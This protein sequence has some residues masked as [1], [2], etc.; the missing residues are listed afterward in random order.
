MS[1]PI[2]VGD[3]VEFVEFVEIE[4]DFQ[5]DN[6]R[7]LEVTLESPSGAVSVIAQSN[8]GPYSSLCGFSS[9]SCSLNG[10]F[11]FGSAR[12]LGENPEGEWILRI[13]DRISGSNP[14]TLRSWRLTIYGHRDTPAAPTIDKVAPGNGAL[15]VAWSA[16]TNVGKSSISAYDLRYILSATTDK[17]D[18]GWTLTEDVWTLSGGGAL[19]HKI[20]GLIVDTQYD[21]QVRAVSNDGDGQWSAVESAAASTDKAPFIESLTLVNGSLNI[22]WS[23][24]TSSELGTVT[25]YDLRY[26]RSDVPNKL[27]ASW[28]ELTFIWT[29]GSLEYTLFWRPDGVSYD[30]QIRAVTGSDQQPWSSAHSAIGHT[31]P[32][33]PS[34]IDI[35]DSYVSA[36]GGHT[37]HVRWGR[38]SNGGAAITGYEIRY[39]RSDATD[40]GDDNWRVEQVNVYP[41]LE[42]FKT[43]LENGV[44]YDV[45]VR[46]VNDAGGGSWSGT[47]VGTPSTKPG[48]LTIDSITAGSKSITV[49]WSEPESDGGAD[50]SSYDLRYIKTSDLS[51]TYKPTTFRSAVWS[52]DDGDLTATVT[53]LEVGTQYSVQV[54]A[55][56]AAGNG[57]WSAWKAGTT[58]L[59]AD[60]AE[61]SSLV[62]TGATL[63]PSFAAQTTSYKA[64]TGYSD[65]QITITAT[66]RR[67]D[68]T[69]EFL[70]ESNQ[71]LTDGDSADGFQVVLSVGE[72]VVRV[73]VT[74]SDNVTT[75]TYTVTVTRLV[76]NSEPTFGT[77]TVTRSV[78]E[79]SSLGTNV[80]AAVTATDS[81][82]DTL[83]YALSGTD[84]SSFTID[85]SGQLKTD[86]SL[87][88]ETT[89][90]YTVTVTV[91]DS[92]DDA[93]VADTVVD[94]TIAV[95]INLTNVDEAGTVTVPSS[96][97]GGTAATA[98][99]T[100][101]DGTVSS[102]SWQWARGNTATGTFNTISEA[103]SAS[104]TPGAADVGKYLRATVTYRDPQSTTTN[105]TASATS[106]STV[107]ASNSAPTFSAETATRT[108]SE[109]SGAGVN[110]VGGVITATDSDS[111]DTLTYSLTGTDAGSF[112]IDSNGQIKTKS[113]VTHNFNFE[114]MSNNSFTVTVTVR[115]SKDDAGVAD[116]VVDDTIAVTINL[117][118]VDEAGTVT[119]PSL[120]SGGTAATASVTDPDGAVSSAS[121]Q[122]AQGNTATGPFNTIGGAT[123]ASYTPVAADVGKYLRATVTYKDPQSTTNKTASAVSSGTVGA[124]NTKPTF[125]D[126]TSATRTVPE[127]SSVETNVGSAVAASDSD[128]PADTLTYGLKSGGDSGSFT[129]VATS[130]Q[131][132]TKTGITYDFEDMSNNSFTVTV[133]VRDSKDDAGVADTVVDDTIAVTINLTNVDEAGTVTLPS[134]FSGG[135]AATASVTDPDGAVSSASWQWAQGNT[136]TGP[137]N[138]IGGATSASYTPVAAD[139]G[140]YLRATVTYKDPQSTTNK[141]A[142]AVSSGTVGASNTKP[143]FDDGTSA[144]RT[145]PENSSVETNVGS[146]VAAS[147]SDTPA[148]TLTYG[149]KSGGD[150]GSFTIV[151]TSGQIQTKTGI[152]YDFEDMSNNSFTVTVTVRDSKDDAG[153]ADTVVDDTIAVTINLTNVNEAPVVTT[154]ATTA[155]V[156]ENS[157][158][159]LMF[160]ASDVDA[161]DTRTWSV[162]AADDGSFFE[163]T[164]GGALSFKSAPDFENK[165]DANTDNVYE[166][167]VKVTDGGNLTDTHDLDVTVT[168]VNEAPEITTVSTTYTAF[169]VDENT[170]TSVVIKTYEATDVDAGSV[171]TWSLQG[172]DRRDFTITRNAQ[173]HGELKFANV[174]NFETPVDS[175]TM[176]GYDIRVKVTDSGSPAMNDTHTVTV[177][178]TVTNVNEAPEITTVS[179]TDTAFSVDE[180]TATSV[181]IK[182]YEATD[183]DAGSVL[184]WSL[185]GNDASDFTITKDAQG[186]GEL[187][188]A[189]VPNHEMPVDAGTDNVY[190]VTV[191]VR[192]NHTGNLTHTLSVVVTVN[193]VNEAP[194]VSGI[195][196]PSFMEIE[197]D[198]TPPDLTIGTYTYTDQDRNPSDTITWDLSGTDETHFDIGSASG[199]LSFDMQPDFENPFGADN[200]YVLVVEAD[201]GQGGVGTFNVAVTVTN[202]DETP[203]ITTTAASHTALSFMEIEYDATTA[204][205]MVADYDGRDEEDTQNITWSKTG[206]DAADF[207]I[208]ANTGV[209]SFAQ[210]PHFEMPVDGGTDNVYNVT[211]R[212]TDTTFPLKAR[213][214]EVTVTVMDVNERP[215]IDE[216]AVPSYM[217]IKYDFT[218]TRPDVHTFTATDYDDMDTV[219]WSLLGTDAAYLEIG[220]TSGILTFRQDSGFGHGPL[221]SF[222]HPR[223]DAGDGSSNTYTITVRA[224]DDDATDQKFTEYAVTITVTDVNEAPEFTGTPETA[225]TLDEHDAND[226]YVV[227][228]LVDYDARDEEGG[229]TWSLTGTDSGEFA[230]SADGVV[231]FD[232]TPNYEAPKDSEG[233]NVYEFMVVATDVQSGSSRRNA[234]IVVTVTVADV[235]EAGTLTVDNLSPAVGETVTFMLTDPDGGIDPTMEANIRWSV[236]TMAP[237][238]SWGAVGGVVSPTS[239]TFTYTVDEDDTGKAIRAVVTYMDRRGPAKMAESEATAAVAADPITNAPP[240]FRGGSTFSIEE[241]AAERTVGVPIPA[242]DRDNDT[243]TFGIRSGQDSDYFEINPTTGQLRAIQ[244]LDFE[245]TA[246]LLLFTVTLHDGKDA[247]G[248][249]ED[250]PV[251]DVTSTVAITVL[252]V[253]EDGVV[254]LSSTEP[255][256]G[257]QLRGTIADGDGGVSG[258]TW[259]WARSEDGRTGWTNISGATS[260]SYTPV[261]ADGAFFLRV[262]VTYTDRR[263]SG[264]S[265]EA[266]TSSLVISENRRPTFPSTENG[267]RT[268]AENTGAGENIGEPVAAE[269]TEDDT[270]V[271]TLVGVDAAYFTIVENT[272][273]LRTKEPLD[274]E[275]KASYTFTIEVHDG[276]DSL[277]QPSTTVDDTQSVTIT[278]ENV[279]EPGTVTLS[280]ATA[281]IQARVEV[282]AELEDDDGPTVVG[283][284][285]SRSPNGR[286]DWVNISGATSATYTPTLEEDKGNYIRALASYDDGHSKNKTANAVSPRVGDAPPINSAP[287]FP[288][289]ENG[290]REVAENATGGATFGDAVVA[291]DFNNDTLYYSLSGTDAESFEIGQNNGQLRL[292]SGVMLDFEGKRSY[293]F[294]VE[295]S[296]R[297]DPLDDP[298]MAIDARQ[299]VTVTVTN[300]NEMPVVTGDDSPSFVENGSNAVA[301]YTGTDPERDTLTWTVSGNDFWISERGQLYFRTP[302]SYEQG[303]SYRVTVTAEDD[304]GLSDA[305]TVDVTVTDVEENGVI[306]L[307]PLRGWDGTTFA[308]VLDDDDGVVG[309]SVDW[310]WQRSSNRSIWNDITGETSI[311]YTATADDVGQYLRATVLYEDDRGMGKDADAGL[312]VRIA[313]SSDRPSTNN[314]PT[315]ADTSTERSVGQGTSAGRSIGAPVRATDEDPDD[316]LTYTLS[317][318]DAGDFDIDRATGQLR[319]KAVLDYDPEGAN[320]YSVQVRVHDG[321]GPDYQSTD[322]GVDATITVTITVTQVAQRVTGGGSGGGGFGPTLVAP[323]FIDGFRTSRPLA[324]NGRPGDAVGDPVAA[325]HP[326]NSDITYSLSGADA[327]RFTVDEETGQIRLGQAV[328]LALGQ[329]YTVNLTATDSSGTGAII[330][331]VIEVAEGVRDPYDLNRDGIISKDEVLKAVSDYFAD[332]IEKDEVLALVARYFAA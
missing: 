230:I 150:S 171:L 266:V 89:S 143:T 270:L 1:H 189:N 55:V 280:T 285:W 38:P 278:V 99:V 264:K 163:I 155:S 39:I 296:D 111:G 21:V 63:H 320:T 206:A 166:V 45:Q 319:T 325:T 185:Q 281:T 196:T 157:T 37:L 311:F 191:K 90:S 241:G 24:P 73:R 190:D 222:E 66:P 194:V 197:F 246:G 78:D 115:D 203:E 17:S 252:D 54:R 240:R 237:G 257:T 312:T 156:G 279:E 220:A 161:S 294:T 88:F 105:K 25:S 91:R 15:T 158:A 68:S 169:N 275:T 62:L 141:T 286:T 214:L 42:V 132:Q 176:N 292:A 152:T 304:G 48:I 164:Q 113:G 13:T 172:S 187:R 244:A 140:K 31:T 300:V 154:S 81:D 305:L 131:I 75:K 116:T 153:V 273:Q 202:I 174:P 235:E 87:D 195:A 5:I 208:D 145:V 250:P 211:V 110:V 26:I 299:N 245:T 74:A 120:F 318:S 225:K 302:P 180:N 178:V 289:T 138:T 16:P 2:T 28:Q 322:V 33:A 159:V 265:A 57:P 128:T 10:S 84:A 207:T 262:R 323:R 30:F 76:I 316:I 247:D 101:P 106:S 295:V 11:R 324:V 184:T 123:S 212:V 215:D 226:D 249:V 254:T 231:T 160:A 23:A 72:N 46:A 102:A 6:F 35:V 216:D 71:P 27:D 228:D 69:V 79:N 330:I 146:A 12:H 255:E 53:G 139:V 263:G 117:T 282:T 315:F 149:L 14:G 22:S 4:A 67:D 77:G 259:Q 108:L 19:Q 112:E 43:K 213:E 192:D 229:V 179:T 100:D 258:E 243:L 209:L 236:E 204:E 165:Q 170:A 121:W 36:P 9:Y 283:W 321:Y 118:N 107:G 94:D 122:W 248:N 239:T 47:I 306:T 293:R 234:S 205:L 124:S 20:E 92:K 272:G 8:A 221:P 331:V 271:Y 181:V 276:R 218:G 227:M 129:I 291:T 95:T 103:T 173:G 256:V 142:S 267:Q 82:N 65:T 274:F 147:D 193:D 238:G 219:E 34:G 327:A 310:Q 58:A 297:A 59:S 269:D 309:S 261:D 114:D 314:A 134:L 298:D 80:G 287:A 32:S 126:G 284:Q 168:N 125:D 328:T 301:S 50:I 96:F 85:S 188:F 41:V 326:Q 175:D 144:T 18:S 119:L 224:T 29:A 288:S 133:T 233:N 83:V 86:A 162:E 242:T 198:A 200:V 49:E 317:G 3:G 253:E 268:V 109:N 290:Q 7:E 151:A 52:S 177:T 223:D 148:D 44:S 97:S 40:K 167:T 217:E 61:L 182:T 232:E 130:G 104:Y 260:S 136:A 51:L 199:V 56:N 201:D 332:L 60:A 135:T 329:T 277:G 127:N 210:R 307:S 98:S 64:S 93:G 251:V 313:D 70:D 183:V 137:F 308:A 303:A 186:R